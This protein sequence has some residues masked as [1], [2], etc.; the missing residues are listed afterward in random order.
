MAKFIYTAKHSE[1]GKTSGGILE[2]KDQS[3]VARKLRSQGFVITSLQED[4]ESKSS[5]QVPFWKKSITSVPLKEKMVF[6]RNLSVMIDSGLPL[7]QAVDALSEQSKNKAF[8]KILREVREAIHSGSTF[9][10]AL[11]KYPSVFNDLFVNMVRV[12]ELGG[13][14]DEVLTIV[15][16]QL[17]K[18]HDLISKVRGAMIYPSVI[19]VAMIGVGVVMLTYILPQILGVFEGMDVEI[20]KTTQFI[21]FLSDLLREQAILVTFVLG[22]FVLG[23]YMLLKTRMGKKMLSWFVLHTPAVRNIVVKVNC[24]R[25]ARIYS[26][27][28]KSGVN[29]VEALGIVSKTLSNTY[30]QEAIEMARKEVQKGRELSAIVKEYKGIFPVLVYQIFHVGEQTGKSEMVLIKLAMF[31]EDEIDQITKN[32]S[33]IIEPILMLFIGGAVGFFAVSMLQPMYSV[34]GN[35]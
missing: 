5:D 23:G 25:F 14:L 20:P 7:A 13:N 29:V 9:A 19:L 2:A 33:S 6:A 17:E 21:I 3:G 1:T 24:A 31:Y 16:T 30:Y 32:L 27:L 22:I 26:S 18:E 12:G 10:E 8:K 4:N 28:L 34:L 35:I 11:E 15:A